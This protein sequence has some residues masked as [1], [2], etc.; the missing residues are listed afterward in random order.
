LFKEEPIEVFNY[1][2]R[3]KIFLKMENRLNKN[4]KNLKMKN[5]LKKKKSL[6]KKKK[7]NLKKRKKRMN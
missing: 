3:K 6:K 2:V 4:K 5:N 1:Y 7:K